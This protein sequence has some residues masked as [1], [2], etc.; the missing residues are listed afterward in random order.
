[1]QVA[2]LVLA[3]AFVVSGMATDR[4]LPCPGRNQERRHG[5]MERCD[6]KCAGLSTDKHRGCPLM[7]VYNGCHCKEGFV[8][9]M[10]IALL[11]LAMVLVVSGMTTGRDR[12]LPCPG[13]NQERR[14]GEME[15]CD[16]ECAD[17]IADEPRICYRLFVSNACHCK[18]GFVREVR[19][20]NC[21]PP[22]ECELD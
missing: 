13:T 8:Q 19:Y 20:G 3:M 18:E 7:F 10:R 22:S 17:L 2:L 1:M 12:S 15:E 16:R 5:G 4:S 11:V 21:I 9:K 14:N 6:K